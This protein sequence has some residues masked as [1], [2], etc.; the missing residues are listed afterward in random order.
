[1]NSVV[2]FLHCTSNC[3]PHYYHVLS[4]F[5]LPFFFLPFSLGYGM[6]MFGALGRSSELISFLEILNYSCSIAFLGEM[7]VKG[8]QEI[9]CS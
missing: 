2:T 3:F 6:G 7:T 8:C 4:R 5:S 9:D 1:M